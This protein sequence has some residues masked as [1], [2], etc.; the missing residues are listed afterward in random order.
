MATRFILRLRLPGTIQ[1]EHVDA[2]ARAEG[3]TIVDQSP[4]MLFVE[5]E[6]RVL[7]EFVT[8]HSEWMLIPEKK[9]SL[10][11]PRLRPRPL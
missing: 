7:Q 6:K 1:Q 9:Y 11:D 2:V 4:K 3:V 5:G 8:A 10:P